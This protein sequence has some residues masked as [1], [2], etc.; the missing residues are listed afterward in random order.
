M[1]KPTTMQLIESFRYRRLAYGNTELDRRVAKDMIKAMQEDWGREGA[2]QGQI[3]LGEYRKALWNEMKNRG[4][5]DCSSLIF[6]NNTA[7]R[8]QQ[9]H[10]INE[11]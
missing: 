5:T 6:P 7:W 1:L 8:K 3:N 10:S 2:I 9:L 11:G 4:L